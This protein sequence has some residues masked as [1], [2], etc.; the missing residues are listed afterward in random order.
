MAK[1]N[2]TEVRYLH[3][4]AFF[5]SSIV[6]SFWAIGWTFTAYVALFIVMFVSYLPIEQED[7][8]SWE[9]ASY[10]L[11]FVFYGLVGFFLIE[12]YHNRFASDTERYGVIAY[13]VVTALIHIILLAIYLP[14]DIKK[15]KERKLAL[16]KR[17]KRLEEREARKRQSFPTG[18]ASSPSQSRHSSVPTQRMRRNA[19]AP[20]Y[21]PELDAD[22]DDTPFCTFDDLAGSDNPY[23]RQQPS[24][25]RNNNTLFGNRGWGSPSS[26]YNSQGKFDPGRWRRGYDREAARYDNE[27]EDWD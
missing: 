12:I 14:G 22:P 21:D 1:I 16:E 23:R 20:A 8:V 26:D 10:L 18:F 2:K 3:H 24:Q 9:G 4:A 15:E 13:F 27:S 5:L 11:S 7:R 17:L 25:P 19:S 6:L